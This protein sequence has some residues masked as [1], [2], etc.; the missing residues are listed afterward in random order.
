MLP[1]L[2]ECLGITNLPAK[3]IA[4]R[5]RMANPFTEHIVSRIDVNTLQLPPIIGQVIQTPVL[6]VTLDQVDQAPGKC[7]ATPVIDL[8]RRH[9]LKRHLVS[10]V[11]R[12]FPA[13]GEHLLVGNQPCIPSVRS[14]PTSVAKVPGEHTA[15]TGWHFVNW[16]LPLYQ[17]S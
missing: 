5:Y 12:P 14:R 7:L 10:F 6:D 2:A 11:D 13:L 17:T 9:Q 1:T 8:R 16:S 3:G 15:I 4:Q